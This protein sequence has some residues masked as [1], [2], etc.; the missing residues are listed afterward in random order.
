MN[1]TQLFSATTF[2]VVGA[3]LDP[4][5]VGHQVLKNLSQNPKL[6]IY[7]INPKGG[8]ILT[9]PVY[10]HLSDTP[11]TPEVVIIAVPAPLVEQIVDEAIS[12]HVKAVLILTAGFSEIGAS[13]HDLE[14]R[15]VSKLQRS[16]ITLLG[17]NSMGYLVPRAQVFATFG[18][19]SFSA[20]HVGLISQSG[21]ILSS[22]FQDFSSNGTGVSFAISI[23]N[24][25]GLTELA[26][27]E[28]A[29]KDP[30][31]TVVA[32][33]LESLSEPS[34][35]LHFASR[36]TPQKPVYL[37]KGGTTTEGQHAALSHTAA[38]ATSQVLLTELCYQSGVVMVQNLEQLA[39]VTSA[40]ASSPYLPEKV[41]ILTNAG[42]E[43][44][45]LTDELSGAG[46]T[47]TPPRDLLGDATP[48]AY[49]VA[50]KEM[51]SDLTIDT[52]IALVSQQSL[53]DISGITAVLQKP[54]GHKLIFA[55]LSGGDQLEPYRRQLKDYGVITTRYPNE[56]A[57]TLVLMAKSRKYL[58]RQGHQTPVPVPPSK[59]Y[60]R[61]YLE[62]TSLLRDYGFHFPVQL[63]VS[64]DAGL[65]ALTQLHWPLIAKSTDLT[66]K[67]KAKIGA[68]M[69]DIT[70]PA[71]AALAYKHL[72]AWKKEVIYQEMV[73]S[74]VE[75]LLGVHRDPVWGWYLAVGLGGSLSDTYDDRSY[76][77]LPASDADFK[78]ALARTKLS[79][80]LTP[81]S[82]SLLIRSMSRLMAVAL[83]TKD[84]TELEINPL[85]VADSEVTAVDL[86]RS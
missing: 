27:L 74:G 52:V 54:H 9:R 58:G 84:L 26:G 73:T 68:V 86:K 42:G 57:D 70:D 69:K 60:P 4:A 23:G 75:V 51:E 6:T 78:A 72:S 85:F 45:I 61:D 21:A 80:L 38:L 1:L 43:G 50:L 64:S 59:P 77:F 53:T 35:F 32:V 7:P 14:T 56:I 48:S 66:L 82:T 79:T 81:A 2:A 33:Y 20:G 19:P 25:G 39:R 62:L 12:L 46:L 8:I 49:S 37:L 29:I 24:R 18:T 22:L 44:V 13:G 41:S 71:K 83:E 65:E 34:A 16:G 55:C 40:A 3:S 47:L 11:T 36:L 17:P 5:K 76:T 67:H 10:P 28:Y 15:I 63:L 30:N 31:T